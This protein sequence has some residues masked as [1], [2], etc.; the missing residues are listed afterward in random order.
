MS[1]P[2][3]KAAASIMNVRFILEKYRDAAAPD[4]ESFTIPSKD[5]HIMLDATQ[6]AWDG[7]CSMEQF[8]DEI[9]K[10]LGEKTL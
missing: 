2:T 1:R 10:K 3:L 5:F 6:Y 8:T 9:I 4:A 7:L